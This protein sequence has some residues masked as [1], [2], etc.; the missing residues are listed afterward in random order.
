MKYAKPTVTQYDGP[1]NS[2]ATHKAAAERR[3]LMFASRGHLNAASINATKQLK[4]MYSDW[5]LDTLLK[6]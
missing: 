4:A 1:N 5:V 2:E 6:K 3:A